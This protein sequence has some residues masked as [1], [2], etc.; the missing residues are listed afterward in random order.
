[1]THAVTGLSQETLRQALEAEQGGNPA[2]AENRYLQALS[3]DASLLDARLRLADLLRQRRAHDAARHHIEKALALAPHDWRVLFQVG[4]QQQTENDLQAAIR[5]Y[6]RALSLAPGQAEPRIQLGL[7]L[8]H[9]GMEERAHQAFNEALQLQPLQPLAQLGAAL[10]NLSTVTPD[11]RAFDSALVAYRSALSALQRQWHALDEAKKQAAL[12]IIGVIQPFALP[13]YGINVEPEQ[14]LYGTIIDG[15]LG[16]SD[17]SCPAPPP[18]QRLRLGIVSAFFYD[19]SNWWIPIKGWLEQLDRSEF[20]V[21]GYYLG[22]TDDTQTQAARHAADTFY[23]SPGEAGAWIQRI[24]TDAPDVLLYPEI[25]MHRET[26]QLACRRLA[27]VQVTSWGHPATSGLKSI[28]YFLSSELMEPD[29]AQRAYV[30]TLH[31]LPGLSVYLDPVSAVAPA[32]R[33]Q[34]LECTAEDVVYWCG[35]ALYKYLPR[36]DHIFARIASQVPGARFIFIEHPNLVATEH[37]RNRLKRAFHTASSDFK[38]HVRVIPRC[39]REQ[40][41]ALVATSDV[42][43]DSLEWSGCNTALEAMACN[44][45]V[46]TLPGATMRSRHIY[47]MLTAMNLQA[48]CATDLDHYVELAIQLGQQ[49]ALRQQMSAEISAGKSALFHD[50]APVRALETFLKSAVKDKHP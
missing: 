4:R 17:R 34:S 28:D 32:D 43:L 3:Q 7:A 42:F 50:R 11:E 15:L 2:L 5:S 38:Q 47:G 14:R 12:D 30:E 41:R 21:Y 13:Y 48:H 23:D 33:A 19:H 27:P 36:Y 24:R 49:P 40:F 6:R 29:N 39:H 45:P 26:L 31:L 22:H 18:R 20:E 44:L 35:Q 37:L 1:M 25:G 10:S 8:F 16:D 46:V 9:Y